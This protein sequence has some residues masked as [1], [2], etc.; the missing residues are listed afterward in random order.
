LSAVKSQ[1]GA[2]PNIL[3][4]MAQSSAALGGYLGFAGALADG[5]LSGSLREQIALAVAG[6]NQCDY[7]ASVHTALGQQAGLSQDETQL[8]LR[9]Q[10]TDPSNH[11]AVQFAVKIVDDRGNVSDA[12]LAAVRDAGFSEE[13]VVEIVANTALN[14]FTNYFNH[15]AGTE[16]EFPLVRT[17]NLAA[18]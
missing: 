10:A 7:C 2:V 9:G 16:I 15:I 13:E 18:A 3:S 17:E 11:A 12:D 14:I 5:K 1:M 8:N 4:T 6:A